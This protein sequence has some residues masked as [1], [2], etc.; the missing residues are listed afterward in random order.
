MTIHLF[1]MSSINC[2]TEAMSSCPQ[3]RLFLFLDAV[4][5]DKLANLGT[6]ITIPVA[7]RP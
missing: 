4:A 2:E 5:V 1:S 7:Q 6:S 3:R